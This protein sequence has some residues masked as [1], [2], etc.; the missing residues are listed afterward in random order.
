M[1]RVKLLGPGLK[2]Q[3][4]WY[5]I[6]EIASVSD[7]E[8]EENKKYLQL[9]EEAVLLPEDDENDTDEETD[10]NADEEMDI[11]RQKAT[12]LGIKVTSNMKKETLLKK[13][14]KIENEK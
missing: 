9:L 8:Y 6:N 4:K 3:N 7:E 12:E 2:L 14:S 10:E 5:W 13:I 11:L 1:K